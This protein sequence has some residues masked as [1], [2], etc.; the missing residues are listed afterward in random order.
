AGLLIRS[1]AALQDVALG[2][3]PENVL[4]METSMTAGMTAEQA[5]PAYQRLLDQA[6]T[7]PGVTAVGATRV[8]P[9]RVATTAGY[10][11][12]RI[13]SAEQITVTAPQT[14]YSVV[15]AGAFA[16]LGIPV[17]R[18]RDFDSSDNAEGKLTAIINETLANRE[19]PGKDPVGHVLATPI[20]GIPA[21][22]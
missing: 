8:P 4:I 17:K 11:I 1:F 6:A 5:M 12:D 13:P 21:K 2:F 9:G 22:A 10:W 20:L 19:F 14:I 16:A 18:G 15:S 7:I 3:R